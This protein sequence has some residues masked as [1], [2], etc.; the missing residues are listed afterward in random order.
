[1]NDTITAIATPPGEG[2]LSIIRISGEDA[3]RIAMI[4]FHPAKSNS[5]LTPQKVVFGEIRDPETNQCRDEVLLTFFKAPKSYTAEDVIEISAHGGTLITKKILALVLAQ[6]A[7]LAEPGEFTRRAFTNGRLDLTQAEAVADVIESA[8]DKALNSAMAQLKGGLSSRLS[9][10]HETLL[11]AQSQLEASIDFSEDGLTFQ[12]RSDTQKQIQQV[13][14][15]LKELV[16]S[17][18]QGKIVREGMQVTLVGKPNVGKSSLLNAL[19][20]EDRAIVTPIAGTTRDTLEERVRIKDIH[21]VIIDSAGL[22][23]NPEMIEEQGIQRTRSALERSDLAIVVFDASE[24]LDDNDKLLMQELGQ[25]PKLV[26]LNKSDLPSSWQSQELETFLAGEQPITLS[27]KTLNGFGT[28][29]EA[30]YQKATSGERIGESLIIT[31]ERHRDHLQQAAHS[32]HNAVNSLSGGLSEE[33]VAVDVT[34]AMD[35]L[36]IILGKTFEEDLL[37]KIFGQFCIGK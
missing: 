9:A 28:L 14:S 11:N 5:D 13:E 18:R 21:I 20:Q 10:L 37:D 35:H 22:R 19:L 31:R 23:N 36:G 32:L 29:K 16:D 33:L 27:A 30:I 4:L 6:G 15:E 12:S 1:M 7:R 34:L 25:K 8:S 2:G 3:L 24:P 26:V 17:F